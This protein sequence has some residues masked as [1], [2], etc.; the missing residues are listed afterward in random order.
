MQPLTQ[1]LCQLHMLAEHGVEANV[2][3]VQSLCHERGTAH[4]QDLAE[5]LCQRLSGGNVD[6]SR[7][8]L[9]LG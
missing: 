1:I 4:Q 5:A 3:I 8:G 7:W 2:W 9:L 6:L